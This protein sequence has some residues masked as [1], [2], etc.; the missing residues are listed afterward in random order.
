MLFLL[1]TGCTLNV[2]SRSVFIKLP[3]YITDRL[4]S[5]KKVTQ[6][7]DSSGLDVLGEIEFTGR[8]RTVCFK[9]TLN[10]KKHFQFTFEGCYSFIFVPDRQQRFRGILSNFSMEK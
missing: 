3:T 2:L 5:Y 1:D 4:I 7:T 9:D 10:S 6:L 8:I